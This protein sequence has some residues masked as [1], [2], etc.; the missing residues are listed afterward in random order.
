M[1]SDAYKKGLVLDIFWVASW[2][3]AGGDPEDIADI[4]PRFNPD[5][6]ELIKRKAG[7]LIFEQRDVE[8]EEAEFALEEWKTQTYL[9]IADE[10]PVNTRAAVAIDKYFAMR[11]A[12]EETPEIDGATAGVVL[13]AML[14]IVGRCCIDYEQVRLGFL[15]YGKEDDTDGNFWSDRTSPI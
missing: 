5:I 11:K 12:L 13:D 7:E 2:L 4:C 14:W 3:L 15:P 10:N 9:E 8:E 6:A 1:V